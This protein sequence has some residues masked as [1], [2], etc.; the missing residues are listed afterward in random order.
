MKLRQQL[1]FLVLLNFLMAVAVYVFAYAFSI[2]SI[3]MGPFFW[4]C[5]AGGF[6]IAYLG[7]GKIWEYGLV[8]LRNDEQE[9]AEL[10]SKLKFSVEDSDGRGVR[11][12]VDPLKDFKKYVFL[13]VVSILLFG[14]F[15]LFLY[16]TFKDSP[17][18]QESEQ[19]LNTLFYAFSIVGAVAGIPPIRDR[20]QYFV[21]KHTAGS[22]DQFVEEAE[23][24]QKLGK[25][26]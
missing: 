11:S 10:I 24:R 12:F 21:L 16:F 8:A 13:S 4:M 9:M 19:R 23:L 22:V 3:S 15:G 26:K 17:D 14:F 20:I 18:F 5:N 6:L 1:Y 25:N 7:V 2:F